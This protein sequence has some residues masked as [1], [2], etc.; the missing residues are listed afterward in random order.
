MIWNP[1]MSGFF[2]ACSLMDYSKSNWRAFAIDLVFAVASLVW[3]Y[4]T[5]RTGDEHA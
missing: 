4:R 1:F 3:A 2:T 5:Q